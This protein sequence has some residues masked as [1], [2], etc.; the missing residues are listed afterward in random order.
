MT[1][2]VTADEKGRVCIKGTEKGHKYLVKKT[3]GGWWV[4]PIPWARLMSEAHS[5][6]HPI[7]FDD[8]LICAIG[9]SMDA[10]HVTRDAKGFL[11]C[12]RIDPWTGIEESAW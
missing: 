12:A 10:K 1:S 2:L 4:M 7:P 11:G 3:E 6:N 9:R 8:C 5:R